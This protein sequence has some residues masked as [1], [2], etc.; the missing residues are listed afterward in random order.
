[1]SLFFFWRFL[2]PCLFLSIALISW[3]LSQE[4]AEKIGQKIYFNECGSKPDKLIWWNEGENF[5]S[6]GIGHF[7]WY[8]EGKQGPFEETFP[9][10]LI[11]LRNNHVVIPDWLIKLKGCPWNSKEEYLDATHA[12]K[13]KE[14][15]DLLFHS[16]SH[17]ARFITQRFLEI[18]STLIQDKCIAR[19][20][21]R[22]ERS[23]QGKYVLIDY[24]HFKGSG[25][26][27]SERYRG[28]GWGL[29]Q[30]L[31]TMPDDNQDPVVSFVKTAQKLLR[32]RVQNA[33]P[34]RSE[35]RWLPGWLSRLD[36]YTNRKK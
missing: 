19:Q 4:E 36:S 7:I 11:F 1:M 2:L 23:S 29:K 18:Y 34:E 30:V 27:E 8:P 15:Q 31:E 22:L 35:E 33:P 9:A 16:I 25:L 28:E 3:E 5:I 26:V 20:I 10:L 21:Q 17:Q 13:K 6:L 14:L 32:K 12:T 24:L